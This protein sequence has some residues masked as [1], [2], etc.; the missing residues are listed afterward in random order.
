MES[1]YNDPNLNPKDV[2]RYVAWNSIDKS[3][4]YTNVKSILNTNNDVV[5][6][7]MVNKKTNISDD[8]TSTNQFRL[9]PSV[10]GRNISV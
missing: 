5:T 6:I 1:G 7:E 8:L 9:L 10:E 4:R 2:E 3:L